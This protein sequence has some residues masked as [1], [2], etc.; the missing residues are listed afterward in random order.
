MDSEFNRSMNGGTKRRWLKQNRERVMWVAEQLGEDECCRIFNM[1]RSTLERMGLD[2][3]AASDLRWTKSDKALLTAKV[4]E[5]GVEELKDEL[6]EL[7][8]VKDFYTSVIVPMMKLIYEHYD[9]LTAPERERQKLLKV[10]AAVEDGQL[11][12][13]DPRL[14]VM[15][16]ETCL[17][18]NIMRLLFGKA[19]EDNFDS[20]VNDLSPLMCQK[21]NEHFSHRGRGAVTPN[22]HHKTRL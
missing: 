3:L 15:S 6:A 14:Y 13:N 12:H 2:A 19:A 9:K 4:A 22:A 10:P 20:P 8:D 16:P 5:A 11:A 18:N 7:D 21:C 17:N 1:K